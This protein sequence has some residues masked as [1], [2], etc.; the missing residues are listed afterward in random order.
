MASITDNRQ[1]WWG[2]DLLKFT[3]AFFIVASHCRL[4]EEIPQ[5]KE[6]LDL[7][8]SIAVPLYFAISA[9]VFTTRM[10]GLEESMKSNLIKHYILRLG[11]LFCLWYFLSLPVTIYRWWNVATLK[12]TLYAVFLGCTAW[13]YWFIK[14]L[15]IN[16]LLLYLFRRKRDFYLLF[17]LSLVVYLIFAYNY[18]FDFFDF[19]YRPYYSFYYHT[20]YCCMGAL[21]ARNQH[22]LSEIERNHRIL[23]F[24]WLLLFVASCY[25][26]LGPLFRLFSIILILPYFSRLTSSNDMR[27]L[28]YMSTIVYMLQFIVIHFYDHLFGDNVPVLSLSPVRYIVVMAFCLTFASICVAFEN[29]F[30]VLRYLR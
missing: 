7:L 25:V 13:G 27:H 12:E 1:Y 14:V 30:P 21:L 2:L 24:I 4:A 9:F 15:G 23:P 3:L 20:A 19:P 29:R 10:D 18:V 16:L 11:I 6:V 28:R 22:I 26:S 5:V 17:L 8:F